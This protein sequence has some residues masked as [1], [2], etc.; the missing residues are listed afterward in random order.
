MIIY[1]FNDDLIIAI[2]ATA[3]GFGTKISLDEQNG[4]GRR[5]IKGIHEIL[6][7]G[8]TTTRRRRRRE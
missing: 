3:I 5:E 1:F 7:S 4:E 8:T 2:I 6:I